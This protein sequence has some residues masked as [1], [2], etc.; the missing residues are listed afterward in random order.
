MKK[1]S[2]NKEKVIR[3]TAVIAEVFRLVDS[4]GKTRGEFF[5]SA[6][7]TI[8]TL[9][10]PIED[11]PSISLVTDRNGE[12]G[13]AEM[14]VKDPSSIKRVVGKTTHPDF[15][16]PLEYTPVRIGLHPFQDSACG[17]DPNP[18]IELAGAAQRKAGLKLRMTV[19]DYPAIELID[20]NGE[21]RLDM[22]VWGWGEPRIAL[23]G[24][25]SKTNTQITH[26]EIVQYRDWR[27]RLAQFGNF[28][29]VGGPE[30]KKTVKARLGELSRAKRRK[31]KVKP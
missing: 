11:G 12:F 25:G 2:A 16:D 26:D 30:N 18:S 29:K 21:E 3:A 6:D 27:Y 14:T 31:A 8:F 7:R 13:Y 20:S 24:Y 22:C 17:Y 28:L 5:T 4:T 15:A 23:N 1:K 10:S 9:N 19:M